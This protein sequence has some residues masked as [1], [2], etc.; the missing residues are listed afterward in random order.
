MATP[1]KL[2]QSGTY[3]WMIKGMDK[4][5]KVVEKRGYGYSDQIEKE[6]L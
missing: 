2:V 3:V 4:N 6:S 1:G 5:G